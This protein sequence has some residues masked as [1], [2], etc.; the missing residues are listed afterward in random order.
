M[1]DVTF[2]EKIRNNLGGLFSTG[3][4][5]STTRDRVLAMTFAGYDH[6]NRISKE[7]CVLF[8][9]S[10]DITI[11]KFSYADISNE[12]V[13]GESEKDLQDLLNL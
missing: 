1:D 5:L 6:S 11:D 10:F 12:S 3:S 8:Q 9:I 2:N 7:Q 4:F 13:F